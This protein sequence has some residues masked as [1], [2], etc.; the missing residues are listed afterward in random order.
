MVW[1]LGSVVTVSQE[2][3]A[4]SGVSEVGSTE[5]GDGGGEGMRQ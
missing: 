2:L 3:R 5:E 4:H 1:W